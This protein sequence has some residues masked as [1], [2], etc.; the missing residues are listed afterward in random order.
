MAAKFKLGTVRAIAT[1][2]KNASHPAAFPHEPGKTEQA[3]KHNSQLA[4]LDR[5]LGSDRG[6]K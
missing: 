6:G 5:K 3:A 1:N 2:A 4:H